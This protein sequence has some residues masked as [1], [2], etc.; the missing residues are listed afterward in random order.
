MMCLP[1]N[2]KDAACTSH[3]KPLRYICVLYYMERNKMH[4]RNKSSEH[5]ISALSKG[6]LFYHLKCST[7]ATFR[8]EEISLI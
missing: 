5:D 7:V 3:V 6:K 4:N 1:K 2:C 8:S